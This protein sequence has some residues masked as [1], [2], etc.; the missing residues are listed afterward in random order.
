M[1]KFFNLKSS[2]RRPLRAGLCLIVTMI[3]F[4]SCSRTSTSYDR[5]CRVYEDFDG[6][7]DTSEV[8]VEISKT[9]GQ[10][11]PD[12]YADYHVVMSSGSNERYEMFRMLARERAKQNDWSC[13]AIR[14]RYPPDAP[15]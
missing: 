3:C 13:D 12:I 11:V 10:K 2:F 8:A 7:P 5:L 4:A 15:P 6:K 1:Q 9:V 14:K